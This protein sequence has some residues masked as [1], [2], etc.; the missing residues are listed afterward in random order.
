[1]TNRYQ[2]HVW[3]L[4]EDDANRQLANGF[5]LDLDQPSSRRIQVLPEVGGWRAVLDTFES[6]HVAE[7]DRLTQRYMVLLI[8]FDGE[9]GRLTEVKRRIP[10]RLTGRVFILGAWSEP[11]ALKAAGLGSYETIGRAIA[12]DC[13]EQTDTTWQHDLLRHNASE[14]NRLRQDVRPILF[15]SI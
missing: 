8:D 7:M 15:Q 3:V 2:P 12:K 14:I 6:D 10:E 4:P 1:M 13:R 5:V 11:E 9:E